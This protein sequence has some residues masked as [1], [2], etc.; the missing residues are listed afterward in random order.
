MRRMHDYGNEELSFE[1]RAKNLVSQMTLE[2]KMSQM[3]YDSP[4]VKRLR[5]PSY[6][7][8]N[9]ALHGVARAGVATM[10]PQAIA[11]A[12]TFDEELIKKI[13]D[14]IS[15]EA[16]A[17]FHEF[18]RKGDHGIYKGLTFWSPNINIF[19]DPRWGRGQE[20]F[21][22]DPF[23]TGRLGVA[24]IRGLQGDDEKYLKTAAC[25]K[26]YVVHSGPESER[27]SF[28]AEVS[29]KDLRETYLPAF[30][31]CIQEG[32]VET[33]MGAYNRTNGEPCC[34]SRKLIEGILRD[35]WHFKGHFVS[36]C[37]A[38]KDFH[39]GH[40]VTA[41][42]WD[43]A[44]LAVNSG[45]DLNCGNAYASLLL[46]YTEGLVSEK[47]IDKAV[48][49]LMTTRMKLGL[50][51]LPE[52][53]K[54]A[55][56]PYDINDC[57]EHNELSL[58]AARR[59]VVLLKNE[60]GMLPLD[61]TKIRNIGVI[62]PNADSRLALKG[63]YYG[64]ASKYIS[65]LEGIQD[66]AGDSARVYYAQGC[67]LCKDQVESIAERGDRFSEALTVAEKSDVVIM[68][69]GL[70][71]TVEGEEN[72]GYSSGDKTDL[73]LP[74]LQQELLER[75]HAAGKP[76]LLVVLSGS[77]LALGWADEN[78]PVILQAWYPGSKGGK[79]LASL[80]FGDYSPSG[81]LPVTFYHTTEELPDFR[82]YSMHNRTYR[83]MSNKALYPF[84]YG[85]S[86]SKFGY[87]G[88]NC[89]KSSIK[90]GESISFS[91]K[92]KNT[93]RYESYEV[94]QLYIKDVKASVEIPR[95][96]L[97]GFR[98]VKLRPEEETEVTFLIRPEDMAIVTT[99]GKTVVEPGEFEVYI[100]GSQPDE[101][102]MDLS[103]VKVLKAEFE[104]SGENLELKD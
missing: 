51:D 11:L 67:D 58:E 8:W 36:D 45:C 71:E 18:Q 102:S 64:T 54:Y 28:N 44:A 91:V 79:A 93:G 61:I 4:A 24:Y 32:N 77:A 70:D 56:I 30:K 60:G 63:N 23:L 22:E 38:L 49:R 14:V 5:I 3:R 25:A 40:N 83:Y 65:V 48:T 101:R 57:K 9:E 104:V 13:T 100:G 85:L 1:D 52:K 92:V 78:I 26:H 20:T 75:I 88:I 86:Y 73:N 66:Y 99:D 33:I 74:G 43:S 6:V 96:S 7:W 53:V 10:F 95:W 94:V 103:G 42:V 2:E 76:I 34:G 15:T 80:L 31:T 72:S 35:E 69:L 55:S 46:A 17:K 82:D 59:S 84:G 90:A 50:F 19:R 81:R 89:D 21:G 16:R 47:T 62:G 37:F 87:S 27:H 97:K 68:C 98:S 39:D 29:E 41:T 12:A